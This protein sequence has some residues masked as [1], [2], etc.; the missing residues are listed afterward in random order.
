MRSVLFIVFAV[1]AVN[2]FATDVATKV[3][4]VF[5][6]N[7]YDGWTY[8]RSGVEVNRDNISHLKIKL[9][10]NYGLESPALDLSGIDSVKVSVVY[11]T[12]DVS[13]P[14]KNRALKFSLIDENG[15]AQSS[16]TVV[17]QEGEIEQE[18]VAVLP[19]ANN[20]MVLKLTSPKADIDNHAAV[21]S[22]VVTGYMKGIAGD[23]NGDGTVDV[24]DINYV[25]NAIMGSGLQV[26]ADVNGDGTIDVTDINFIINKMLGL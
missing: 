5:D 10:G 12:V 18:I 14:A 17:G 11:A 7:N 23:A 22:V 4:G 8:T 25:V 2:V 26:N 15:T 9:Y 13:L 16:Q 21:R 1:I 20:S 19:V 3:V 6:L 24:S